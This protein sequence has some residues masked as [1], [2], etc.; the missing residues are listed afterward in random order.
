[1]GLREWQETARRQV[2]R[3][4]GDYSFRISGVTLA[5]TNGARDR[6]AVNLE[7]VCEGAAKATNWRDPGFM[8]LDGGACFFDAFYDPASDAIVGFEAHAP[9]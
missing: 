1:V 4:L 3:R 2:A 5:A 9:A 6:A 7:G 8:V